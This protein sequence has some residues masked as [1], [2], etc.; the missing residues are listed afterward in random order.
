MICVEVVLPSRWRHLEAFL[1]QVVRNYD[2]AGRVDTGDTKRSF[3]Y[4]VDGDTVYVGSNMENAI[5]EEFGT[6]VHAEKGGRQTKWRYRDRHG[7]WHT[8]DGKKG[9]RA[10]TRAMQDKALVAKR[11]IETK[12]GGIG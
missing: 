6:G 3:G 8:T 1:A 10:L 2:A 12:L 9:T 7:K 11:I 4:V 5:W